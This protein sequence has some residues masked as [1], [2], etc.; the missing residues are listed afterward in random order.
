[1]IKL[2]GVQG[3]QENVPKLEINVDTVYIRDNIEQKQDEEGNNYWQYDEIQ[4][5]IV[6][7]LKKVAVE[8]E[9]ITDSAIAELSALIAELQKQSD[10]AIAELSIALL[11]KE[12]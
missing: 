11:S 9:E 10:E 5:S 4:Y 12:E 8:N 2:I 1:M 3:T 7:Y 6:E